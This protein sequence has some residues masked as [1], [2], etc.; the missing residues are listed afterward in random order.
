ML[1]LH[2][3]FCI[4]VEA[5]TGLVLFQ[6][7]EYELAVTPKKRRPFYGLY[8]RTSKYTRKC[9]KRLEDFVDHRAF[10]QFILLCILTNTFRYFC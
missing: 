6:G 4:L 2:N 5:D 1:P 9:Q 10:Q 8:A 3:F 7:N